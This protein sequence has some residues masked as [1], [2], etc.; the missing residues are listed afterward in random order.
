MNSSA[1]DV[2]IVDVFEEMLCQRA[3]KG[4]RPVLYVSS[5]MDLECNILMLLDESAEQLNFDQV[6]SSGDG[7]RSHM[8]TN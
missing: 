6:T 8:T 2:D 4:I 1:T 3:I 7:L 5:L